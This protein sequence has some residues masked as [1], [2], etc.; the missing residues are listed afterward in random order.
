MEGELGG[1]TLLMID[2]PCYEY[3][4]EVQGLKIAT[5]GMEN[6]L[7]E[8]RKGPMVESCREKKSTSCLLR[9]VSS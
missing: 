9:Y 5:L 6:T 1:G 4:E 2:R 3:A 7:N 8:Q